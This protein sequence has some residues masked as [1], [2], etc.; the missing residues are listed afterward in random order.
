[1]IGSIGGILIALI[2]IGIMA[3]LHEL[4]HYLVGRRLGFKINTFQIFVGPKLVEWERNDI[5]YKICCF[6]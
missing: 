5:T 1:M 6:L 4:G 2:L 3:T